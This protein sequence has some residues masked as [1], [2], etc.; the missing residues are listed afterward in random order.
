MVEVF[1]IPCLTQRTRQGWAPSLVVY[2]GLSVPATWPAPKS[3][4]LIL[5]GF[6]SCYPTSENPDAEHPIS[7][8]DEV[9]GRRA[10]GRQFL[11]SAAFADF[12]E[13]RL[14]Q[15]TSTYLNEE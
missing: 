2:E 11:V 1:A 8:V 7:V 14:S 6:T 15:I 10:I 13:Q 4:W 5:M 9:R 3:L 12:M